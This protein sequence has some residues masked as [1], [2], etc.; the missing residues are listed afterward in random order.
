[1]ILIFVFV[2]IYFATLL[3]RYFKF[4]NNQPMKN[5]TKQD[6]G[7]LIW[8]IWLSQ[9]ASTNVMLSWVFLNVVQYR[10]LFF[11]VSS[12]LFLFVRKQTPTKPY[13][14]THLYASVPRLILTCVN[15]NSVV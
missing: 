2:K 11:P 13:C 4:S 12:Y 9:T 5:N 6:N 10:S 8:R 7:I 3:L 14:V 15:G 1:M